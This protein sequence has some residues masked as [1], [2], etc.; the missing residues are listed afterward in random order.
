MAVNLI[1]EFNGVELEF[2]IAD[3]DQMS[4]FVEAH[5]KMQ[6]EQKELPKGDDVLK[7]IKAACELYQRFFDR[8][9]GEGTGE[10]LFG[11]RINSRI[12]EEAVESF[13]D[14]TFAQK[15]QSD[16]RQKALIAKYKS[17]KRAKK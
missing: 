17:A 8:I 4:K 7:L 1:W 3:Y 2:D 5:K 9:F 11:G 6:E 12:G 14:F 15:D 16:S 10:K 13:V